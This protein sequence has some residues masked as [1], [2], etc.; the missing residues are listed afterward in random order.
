MD[1]PMLIM[2]SVRLNQRPRLTLIPTFSMVDIMDTISDMLATMDTPTLMDFMESV[3]L[4]QRPRLR[5]TPTFSMVDTMDTTWDILDTMDMLDTLM[6]T[7]DKYSL[8]TI[9]TCHKKT[10]MN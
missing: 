6:L 7:G 10:I 1:I 9:K 8:S 4:N 3:R 2:E 5:L